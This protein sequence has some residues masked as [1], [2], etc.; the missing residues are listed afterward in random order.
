MPGAKSA[1]HVPS[2]TIERDGAAID[3]KLADRVREISIE[4]SLG[5]PNVCTLKM[6]FPRPKNKTDPHEIDSQ[7]FKIGDALVIKLGA[8]ESRAPTTI[9]TGE[10]LTLEPEFSAGGVQLQVRAYDKTHRMHRSRKTQA[11]QDQTASDI[12][13]K[14]VACCGISVEV[15][16][17][18]GPYKF[19]QQSNETDWDF[20]N[21]LADRVGFELLVDGTKVKFQKPGKG[22]KVE[23][24]WSETLR[25]FH[26]RVTAVQ[27]VD[28]VTLN[29]VDPLTDSVIQSSKNNP[30]QIAKIGLSRDE[31]G[32]SFKGDSI[33]V[34]TAPVHNQGEAD[35]LAQAMLDTIANSYIAAE[36]SAPGNPKIKAGAII[37]VKGVGTKFSGTYRVQSAVHTLRGGGAYET[38]FSSYPATALFEDGNGNGSSPDFAG[39]LVLAKVTQNE[40]PEKLGRVKVWYPALGAKHEGTWT[41]VLTPSAG[42]ERGFGM[43]P[44]VDEEVLVG[45]ESGDATRPHVMGSLNNSRQKPGEEL[46]AKDGSYAL[47]SDQKLIQRSKKEMIISSDDKMTVEITGAVEETFKAAFKNEVK[48]NAENKVG[49]NYKLEV[50]GQVSI[51]GG[52]KVSI[53]SSGTMAIKATQLDLEGSAM[54]NIKGGLINIG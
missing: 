20:C 15:E 7:P 47:L 2:Y 36:G 45:F 42:K 29:A 6:G 23:L 51:K 43:L 9:F 19:M 48:Q 31:V 52:P 21:R 11:W 46:A 37:D 27:Q 4:D 30:N 3:Q 5:L 25:S 35:A 1:E 16:S 50:T 39:Q 49:G 17:S 28:K 34:A 40:D 24:E 13:K 14:V 22:E 32:K 44:Q 12:V 8:R 10:V 18:G 41:R 33:H 26:P 38:L 54:V 53:E